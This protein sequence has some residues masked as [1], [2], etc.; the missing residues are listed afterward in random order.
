VIHLAFKNEAKCAGD[1]MGA[2]E[3]DQSA[4]RAIGGTL[5]DTGKPS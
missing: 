4:V 5:I 2:V 3:S 1:F